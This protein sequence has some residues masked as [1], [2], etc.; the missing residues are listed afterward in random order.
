MVRD[1]SKGKIYK[2]CCKDVNVKEI[3]VGST[4]NMKNRK[5]GHKTNCTNINSKKYNYKVYEYIRKNDNWS[6]WSMV[7]IKDFPCNSKKELEAEEDK[8]MRELNATLNSQTGVLNN[9]EYRDINRKKINESKRKSYHNNKDK[10]SEK[11]KVKVKCEC[12]CE[13]RKQH[14]PRHLKTKKHQNFISG[15]PYVKFKDKINIKCEC[16]C[17]IRKEHLARHRKTKKHLD[18][19]SSNI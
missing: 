15:E 16:G 19:L 13:I 17:E 10:I 1:Y 2:L 5:N 8:I 9:K 6:N 7:W 12:G 4:I 18:F 14:L 3:Y 11:H